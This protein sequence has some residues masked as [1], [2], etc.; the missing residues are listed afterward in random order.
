MFIDIC[1]EENH[2]AQLE[3][4]CKTH[5]ELCCAACISKIKDNEYG[6]HKDCNVCNVEEIKDDKKN[7]LKKN[8]QYLE[9]L[10]NTLQKSIDELKIIQEKINNDKQKLKEDILKIFTNLR[11]AINEREDEI[12]L[13]VD[14][15]FNN[16]FFKEEIVKESEKLPKKVKISL[17]NGKIIDIKWENNKELC[18]MIND[19]IKIE[20]YLWYKYNK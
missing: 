18:S 9:E 13:D 16:L 19:C 6:K 10:S 1:Q 17:E 4:F 12:L 15:K 5:N 7:K 3:F 20:K 11:N 2:F 14:E 8:I